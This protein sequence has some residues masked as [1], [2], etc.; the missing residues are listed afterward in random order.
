MSNEAHSTATSPGINAISLSHPQQLICTLLLITSPAYNAQAQSANYGEVQVLIDYAD[1][2]EKLGHVSLGA[3]TSTTDRYFDFKSRTTETTGLSWLIES[4]PQ[5]QAL[6]GGGVDATANNETNLIAQWYVRDPAD[7][8]R[9]NLLLWYQFSSTWGNQTTSDFQNDIGILSPPNGGDTA[10]D[11]SRD[12]AQHIAWEQ[13]FTDDSVRI[14]VGKLTTRV[15]MNLNRYAV[16]DREDFFTPMIVNNPVA[17]YTA[18]AGLGA[19][20]EYSGNSWY[21]SGMLR[22]ADADL[23]KR[24]ADF[25]SLDSGNWE[26]LAESG[27]TPDDVLGLGAG[28]YR[29]TVSYSDATD[30]ADSTSSVSLSFDQDLG[31]RLGAYFRYATANDTFRAFDRRIA[32]GLQI[33]EPLGFSN[34]RIGIG[35]WWGSPT[36]DA[37]R[38]ESGLDLYWKLQIARFLEVSAGLQTVFDPA[39]DTTQDTATLAQARLRFVF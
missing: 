8:G 10:P 37:L 18:R 25:S 11:N 16:S 22:D 38:S 13:R 33:K 27:L 23:S 30:S 35:Y 14:Q 17:H 2:D 7:A 29:V 34:D 20:A 4:A 26:Y 15:L 24:L 6:L 3:V 31:N 21:V 36:D 12:L 19:F 5:Y 9:G 1:R 28:N 32:M 39:F